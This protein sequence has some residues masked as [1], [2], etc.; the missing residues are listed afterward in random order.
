MRT[1]PEQPHRADLPADVLHHLDRAHR[2]LARACELE[3]SWEALVLQAGVGHG[4]YH[5][6]AVEATVLGLRRLAKRQLARAAD[7]QID[8]ERHQRLADE[9]RDVTLVHGV[10]Q[11]E[12]LRLVAPHVALRSVR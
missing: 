2:L 8:R 4:N 6:S 1:R 10:G 11:A 9:A 12:A 5:G 7:R 3:L